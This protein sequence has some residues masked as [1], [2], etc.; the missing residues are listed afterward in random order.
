MTTRNNPNKNNKQ[1]R[2]KKRRKRRIIPYFIII[3]FLLLSWYH[4]RD[5][6]TMM[7]SSEW[8]ERKTQSEALI[9]KSEEML[10]LS[11]KPVFTVDDGQ[12]ISI[13]QELSTANV[14]LNYYFQEKEN[15]LQT[16]MTNT[17]ALDSDSQDTFVENLEERPEKIRPVQYAGCD[18]STLQNELETL[19]KQKS[20]LEGSASLS[21]KNLGISSTGY[22][23][24]DA[25]GYEYTLS[26]ENFS[27]FSGQWMDFAHQVAQGIE[28]KSLFQAKV[29]GDD[30][31]Y[32]V[33]EL[34]LD[35]EIQ[36]MERM[37]KRK[38]EI[39]QDYDLKTQEDYFAFLNLRVDLLRT[40]PEMNFT[41]GES[42]YSGYFIDWI[43][44]PEEETGFA[45]IE[46]KD[47]LHRDF[48]SKRTFNTNL[49]VYEGRGY[50]VPKSAVYEKQDH[51]FVSIVERGSQKNE[52]KV[53]PTKF[54][55]DQVFLASDDN[56]ALYDGMQIVINP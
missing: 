39:R 33:M 34:P 14:S 12:R 2:R 35:T 29:V 30:H 7:L 54:E 8:Y 5:R 42:E 52:V 47:H 44:N 56:E 43:E 3:L 15:I 37:N 45:V 16:A 50:V 36:R 22:L 13:G 49:S 6:Q 18:P 55:E 48:L 41:F 19:K 21:L 17:F 46:V 31:A 24:F 26:K 32:A 9:I 20:S 4:L 23:F 28:G 51:Y 25:D 27:L 10:Y 1:N 53:D 38:S 40:M 11:P